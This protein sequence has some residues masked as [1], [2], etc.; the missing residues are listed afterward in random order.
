MHAGPRHRLQQQRSMPGSVF[1]RR[2]ARKLWS[3]GNSR[4]NVTLFSSSPLCS[5]TSPLPPA[6]PLAPATLKSQHKQTMRPLLPRRARSARTRQD[7]L[8]GRHRHRCTVAEMVRG[9]RLAG[10][11]TWQFLGSHHPVSLQQSLPTPSVLTKR[12][13]YSQCVTGIY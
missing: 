9:C 2:V 6:S 5:S 11:L 10:S 8:V 13:C 1:N 7:M 3:D 4:R 12:I